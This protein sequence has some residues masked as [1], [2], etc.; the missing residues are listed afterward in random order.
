MKALDSIWEISVQSTFVVSLSNHGPAMRLSVQ[1]RRKGV[2]GMVVRLRRILTL[3]L[4]R[5]ASKDATGSVT[6]REER[7]YAMRDDSG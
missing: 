1:S 7:T 5:A 4:Q 2:R 6:A 3:L